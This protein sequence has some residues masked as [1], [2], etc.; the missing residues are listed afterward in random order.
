MRGTWGTHRV[1]VGWVE[2]GIIGANIRLG[3]LLIRANLVTVGDVTEALRRQ[4]G[5]GGRLGDNLVTMGV[6]SN[7][8]LEAFLK[9]IPTEPADLAATRIDEIDLLSLLMRLIYTSRLESCRQFVEAIRLPYHIVAELVAMAVDRKLLR[10]LGM[11]TSD[12]PID[13]SYTF[14]DEGKRWTLD[15]LERV[16][17]AGPA[18]VTLEEFTYQVS[19]Q[20]LTNE[21]S[22]LNA[23]AR[24]WGS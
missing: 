14:S 3:D 24:R 4:A 9:R 11:R 2:E 1:W 15:A 16:S 21:R 10:T 17:Y 8:A 5:N 7:G 12:N 13:M 22:R 18:P 23:S 6:L 20:K 19:V